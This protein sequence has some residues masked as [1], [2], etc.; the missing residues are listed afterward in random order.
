MS[1]ET[2]NR[3]KRS[4]SGRG[5]DGA[6]LATNWLLRFARRRPG[7]CRVSADFEEHAEDPQATDHVA[8]HAT[9]LAQAGFPMIIEQ[10]LAAD[11]GVL[12]L[13]Q[14]VLTGNQERLR[15]RL[16]LALPG[17]RG[18][19]FRV[20]FASRFGPRFSFG[21][22][23]VSFN[24]RVCPRPRTGEGGSGAIIGNIRNNNRATPRATDR[25]M[26]VCQ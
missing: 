1:I 23:Q 13:R 20:P 2:A 21:H 24:S 12:Q 4:W 3:G 19:R 11:D 5:P 14:D 18:G 25:K 16:L 17:Q 22:G 6:G 9:G 8:D 15:Q 10:F 7:L 26:T